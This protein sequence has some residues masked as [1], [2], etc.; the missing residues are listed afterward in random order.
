MMATKQKTKTQMITKDTIIADLVNNHPATVDVLLSEGV[1]CVGCGASLHESIEEGLAVHGKTEED[2]L[3]VVEKLN[4]VAKE[5]KKYSNTLWVTDKAVEKI[6]ELK[7]KDDENKSGLRVEVKSGGCAGYEYV[8]EFD[9]KKDNDK[10]LDYDGLEIYVDKESLK[11]LKGARIDY[12]DSLQGAG[13]KI[14]NPNAQSTC[15]CGDS[16]C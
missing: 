16:F 13:F 15:G 11:V 1:N 8:L 12:I 7:G 6:K 14:S 3:A 4:K 9:N 2:I 5:E 10:I